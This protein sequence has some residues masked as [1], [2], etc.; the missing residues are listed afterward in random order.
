MNEKNYEYLKDQL[1]YTGFG[2]SLNNDLKEKMQHNH[3]DFNIVQ[4]VKIGNDMCFATLHFNKSEKSDMYFFNKYNLMLKPERSQELMEQTFY[5]NK[6]NNV[7][8]K[9]AYN[10]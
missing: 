10:L 9:E 2:E 6:G 4:N 7:T 8:L 1:K 3:K 5:V